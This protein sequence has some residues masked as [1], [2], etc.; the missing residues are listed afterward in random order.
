MNSNETF[1]IFPVCRSNDDSTLKIREVFIKWGKKMGALKNEKKY[2]IDDIYALP[3]DVPVGIYE[4]FH[5][6]IRE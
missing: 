1:R 5:I 3:D 2:G 4:G 6:H